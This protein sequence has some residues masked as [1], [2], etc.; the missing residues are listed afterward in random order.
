MLPALVVDTAAFVL[1]L[2]AGLWTLGAGIDAVVVAAGAG[3]GQWFSAAPVALAAA[4]G[5]GW[6]M[7][8]DLATPTPPGLPAR[9]R[10]AT[11]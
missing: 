1:F 9:N 8:H 3:S 2:L 10:T 6:R 11:A 5:F 4:L 7:L